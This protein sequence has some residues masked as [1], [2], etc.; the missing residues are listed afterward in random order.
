VNQA[1]LSRSAIFNQVNGSLARLETD[2]ID[3]LQIH[4]ADLKR[5]TAEVCATAA[6]LG[7]G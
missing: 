4:R 5:V 1:G 6:D 3:L 7:C 2:Y